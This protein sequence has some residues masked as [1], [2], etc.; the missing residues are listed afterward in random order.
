MAAFFGGGVCSASS[1][2]FRTVSFD[3][4]AVV[5]DD[6][7]FLS[8]TV[9]SGFGV[10]SGCTFPHPVKRNMNMKSIAAR[11]I[12][13]FMLLL[14]ACRIVFACTWN[15]FHKTFISVK[16]QIKWICLHVHLLF[17]SASGIYSV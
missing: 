8:D 7:L 14:S 9:L 11:L 2:W 6:G 4:S 10:V 3:S 12:F 1:F 5:P 17:L 13:D 15:V 16:Q